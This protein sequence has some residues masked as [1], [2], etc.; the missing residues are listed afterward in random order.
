MKELAEAVTNLRKHKQ[1]SK[2]DLSQLS[3][4]SKSLIISIESATAKIVAPDVIRKLC[5]VLDTDHEYLLFLADRLDDSSTEDKDLVKV[6]RA[7]EKQEL[8]RYLDFI[9]SDHTHGYL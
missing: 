2:D 8:L 7:E 6:N 3:G 9:H 1:L 4:V 5:A